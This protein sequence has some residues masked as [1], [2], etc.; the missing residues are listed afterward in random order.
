MLNIELDQIIEVLFIITF[1]SIVFSSFL[2]CM[3]D[4]KYHYYHQLHNHFCILTLL[5]ACKFLDE[6]WSPKFTLIVAQKNHH[7]KFFVPG[8]QNNVPPGNPIVRYVV[9]KLAIVHP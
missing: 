5:Q 8:S 7:T 2:F 4:C 1:C 3:Q 9:S 6:N